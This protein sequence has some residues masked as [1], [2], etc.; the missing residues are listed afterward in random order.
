M[1]AVEIEN[2]LQ[3][4]P[5]VAEVAVIGVDDIVRGKVVKAFI[6]TKGPVADGLVKELQ[7]F[8]RQHL[9]QH[10]YPR[11]IDFVQSLPKTPAGK[12]NRKILRD[13]EAA[14]AAA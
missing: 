6:V 12:I 10:E 9:S 11:I 3:K 14:L 5:S 8:T 7:A 4:H 2:V 13:Q 1:S